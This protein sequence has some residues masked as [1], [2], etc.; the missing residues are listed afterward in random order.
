[1]KPEIIDFCRCQTTLFHALGFLSTKSM[2]V[3][4]VVH[5]V[6]TLERT[7]QDWTSMNDHSKL[8]IYEEFRY[9][10][11]SPALKTRSEYVQEEV[12]RT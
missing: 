9:V 11:L 2:I 7:V 4:I 12:T 3:L 5:N 1:M 6:V 8:A 10:R